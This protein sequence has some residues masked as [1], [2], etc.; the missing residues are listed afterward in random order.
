[1]SLV[2]INEIAR[3][4]MVSRHTVR[5]WVRSGYIPHT[6]VGR[7]IRFDLKAVQEWV[8]RRACPGRDEQTPKILL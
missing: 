2:G 5:S 8:Q 7:L 3:E 1:M 4:L 6:R